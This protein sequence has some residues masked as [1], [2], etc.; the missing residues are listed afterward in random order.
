MEASHSL[1]PQPPLDAPVESPK[2]PPSDSSRA[3]S[4]LDAA[5]PV[6]PVEPVRVHSL[7]VVRRRCLFVAVSGDPNLVAPLPRLFASEIP[8]LELIF[9]DHGGTPDVVWICGAGPDEFDRVRA[10]RALYKDSTLVVTGRDLQVD[11]ADLIGAG[12]DRVLGW[13][14]PVSDLR[15]ALSH[16]AFRRADSSFE[17]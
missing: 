5:A 16:A 3:G 14:S 4:G 12:A 11:Q 13:P 2:T 17:R 10:V 7:R 9:E 8:D 15:D 1:Q 6:F